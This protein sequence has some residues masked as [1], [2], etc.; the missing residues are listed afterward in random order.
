MFRFNYDYESSSFVIWLP[1]IAVA[2][3]CEFGWFFLFSWCV[4]RRKGTFVQKHDDTNRYFIIIIIVYWGAEKCDLSLKHTT[5][6]IK[7]PVF[8]CVSVGWFVCCA[9]VCLH[10]HP[11]HR[12]YQKAAP[13]KG[14]PLC[15][16]VV[17]ARIKVTQN[18]FMWVTI[19]FV[20]I[21]IKRDKTHETGQPNPTFSDYTT[22]FQCYWC[23]CS[24]Y[25][26]QTI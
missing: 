1:A 18:A 19:S 11:P 16:R 22:N 10:L 3:I 14:D 25:N 2:C 21:H 8:K 24:L 23:V 17:R 12:A 20:D 13:D 15:V 9:A 26:E 4:K 6:L 7:F 5:Q